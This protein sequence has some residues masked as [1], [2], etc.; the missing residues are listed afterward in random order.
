MRKIV[1][2]KEMQEIEK[3]AEQF[4]ISQNELM[5]RAGKQ[6]AD[7]IH[8][9][10][11]EYNLPKRVI[12]LIG[13][14]NN[15]ADAFVAARNLLSFGFSVTC[16]ELFE[17][18]SKSLIQEKKKTYISAGGEVTQKPSYDAPIILDGIFGTGFQGK[19]PEHI[20]AIIQQINSLRALRIAI[21]IPSG[22]NGETGD[23]QNGAFQADYTITFDYPKQGFYIDQGWDHVG[24]VMIA[25]IGLQPFSENHEQMLLLEQE[26][27][28]PLIPHIQRS[29]HKY[30]RGHVVGLAGSHGMAGAALLASLAALKTGAGIVHLLH[31][32]SISNEI[33]GEPLEVVRVPYKDDTIAGVKEWIAKAKSCFVGPGL[34]TSQQTDLLLKTIWNDL[35]AKSVIDADALTFLAKSWIGR[36]F[37]LNNLGTL[38]SAIL[39]PHVGEMR[40]LL[41]SSSK[42]RVKLA[43]LKE[44]HDFVQKNNTNLVLKGGPSFLFSHNKPIVVMACSDPGMATA[45]SGDVLTGMLAS[46]LAQG[47]APYHALL[48]GTYLHGLAGKIA[49]EKNSSYSITAT[50]IIEAIP[51]AF[52]IL[53]K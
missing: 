10:A 34:G 4:G 8:N 26:D 28:L 52:K 53:L 43:F 6:V 40:K 19:L 24:K 11:L 44:V 30:E 42:E 25:E 17:I 20:A 48:L 36:P 16:V 9:Y 32:E 41:G 45:G 14:G 46:L 29:C 18:D 23:V 13:K 15:G 31:P 21:D 33:A 22:L 3:R 12:A 51:S 2:P 49:A 47:V 37:N 35:K 38:P 27:V 5:E 1:T 7:F 39:T 50:S